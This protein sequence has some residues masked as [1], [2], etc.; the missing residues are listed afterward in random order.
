MDQHA[1][2]PLEEVVEQWASIHKPA[3]RITVGVF[4][5]LAILTVVGRAVIRLKT[6]RTLALDDYLLFAGAAFLCGA[7][8]LLYSIVDT[9]YLAV[10]VQKDQSTIFLLTP[11]QFTNLIENAVQENHAFLMVAWTATFLVKFSFLAFFK[12]LIWQVSGIRIYYW[13][14]VVITGL[15]WAFLVAEPF[16]LCP[17]FGVDSSKLNEQFFPPAV[18]SI[19]EV[20]AAYNET[21]AVKCFDHSR[22]KLY[23]GLTGFIT[24]LDALTDIMIV[25][26]PIIILRRSTMKLV[27]KCALGSFL[28]LSLVMVCI[29]VIRASKINGASGVDVPWEFF[30]QYME[31]CVAVLM[32]SLTVFRSVLVAQRNKSS[33][34][35]GERKAGGVRRPIMSYLYR[36]RQRSSGQRVSGDEDLES[37][38]GY[39]LPQIPGGTV[40]GLRTYIR[41]HNRDSALATQQK[42]NTK[43]TSI[44]QI[45]TLVGEEDGVY[46]IDGQQHGYKQEKVQSQQNMGSRH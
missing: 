27:Q 31:A 40:T 6:R 21:T 3:F 38:R 46:L 10:A 13:T 35:D 2:K 44:S 45:D 34:G 16:I 11:D 12:Q 43:R 4:F 18:L 33:A 22:D 14:V 9:L 41:R 23:I 28:C 37:Q 8:G 25:S 39:G 17:Y 19:R 30:W 1:N 7:T 29:A 24:G 32:G 15:S 20:M 36:R 26:I 5:S 42:L